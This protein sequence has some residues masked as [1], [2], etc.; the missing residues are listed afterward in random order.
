MPLFDLES[1]SL[2]GFEDEVYLF[3]FLVPSI[4]Q[5]FN[6]K[7][8]DL[9]A[10]QS[11]NLPLFLRVKWWEERLTMRECAPVSWGGRYC[12]SGSVSDNLETETSFLPLQEDGWYRK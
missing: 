7:P 5:P 4:S 9:K 3:A 10:L 6:N 1:G 8:K 2:T 12:A 11:Y